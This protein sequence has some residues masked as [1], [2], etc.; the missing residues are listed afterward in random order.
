VNPD[1]AAQITA[2]S[3][4]AFIGAFA[5]SMKVATGVA[6]AGVIVAITLIRSRRDESGADAPAG[7]VTPAAELATGEHSVT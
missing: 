7:G 3:R 4:D 1:Q 2:A 6:I 5:S